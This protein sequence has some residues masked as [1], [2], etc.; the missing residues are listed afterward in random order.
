VEFMLRVGHRNSG[1]FA[2]MM[3]LVKKL[4]KNNHFIKVKQKSFRC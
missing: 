1:V 4:T 3:R 2:M